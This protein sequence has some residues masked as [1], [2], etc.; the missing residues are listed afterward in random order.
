MHNINDKLQIYSILHSTQTPSQWGIIAD[1]WGRRGG[2]VNRMCMRACV[3]SSL[4]L[5]SL[6]SVQ[7][8]WYMLYPTWAAYSPT[9]DTGRVG[10]WKWW[11]PYRDV[12]GTGVPMG[13]LIPKAG[14]SM[15]LA[16]I[17]SFSS[18]ASCSRLAFAL[19]FWNQIFTWVSVK[20]RELE[21]SA[22][23]AM[24]RYCFWRNFR[25]RAS[26]CEVVNG[27]LGLRLVLCFLRV[28]AGGLILPKIN[29][30]HPLM[31]KQPLAPL[32]PPQDWTLTTTTQ[33]NTV[34]NIP[35]R[36]QR[37]KFKLS[38]PDSVAWHRHLPWVEAIIL[39][40]VLL[41]LHLL[42]GEKRESCIQAARSCR[43]LLSDLTSASSDSFNSPSTV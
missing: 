41:T 2:G 24:D 17:F 40:Q 39:S 29:T 28:Q 15:G 25:S 5:S 19:R 43:S 20:L 22:L 38:E 9:G 42:G 21:N 36:Q 32:P 16:A 26:N 7:A 14:G 6:D 13:K 10:L 34:H 30:E 37:V 11:A 4:S 8:K 33:Y 23:S 12:A 3:I 1:G 18:S 35:P 27:V 31:K